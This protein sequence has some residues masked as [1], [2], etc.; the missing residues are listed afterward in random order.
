MSTLRCT[1]ISNLG[2]TATVPSDTVVNGSAKAWVNFNGT[3]QSITSS[4]NVSTITGNF[5]GIY[6]VNLT[7]ALPSSSYAVVGSTGQMSYASVPEFGT[8][9]TTS[10]FSIDTRVITGISGDNRAGGYSAASV[11]AVVFR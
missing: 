2:G 8:T 5:A 7:N 4:F 1:T 6:T 10:S 11:S 3:T 9:K